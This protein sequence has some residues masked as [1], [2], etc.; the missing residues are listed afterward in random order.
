[1]VF[2][3]SIR[4]VKL[5]EDSPST[6]IHRTFCKIILFY[7]HEMSWFD[8]DEQVRGHM[9]TWIVKYTLNYQIT[10]LN[11]YFVGILN[12]WIVL[13]TKYTTL[14]V[15]QLK[16]VSQY[17]MENDSRRFSLSTRC[18]DATRNTWS[19]GIGVPCRKTV[20]LCWPRTVPM[21]TAR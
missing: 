13:P 9:N 4:M 18:G 3:I 16:R 2:G 20:A 21:Y 14:N 7:G 8:D 5:V 6:L 10:E 11:K 1:M 17:L 19:L 12:S 15:E